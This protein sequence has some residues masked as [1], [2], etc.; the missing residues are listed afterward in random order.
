M[1]FWHFFLSLLLF[2]EFKCTKNSPSNEP[3]WSDGS[4]S[5]LLTH[6]F[7]G[8]LSSY[9]SSA[10]GLHSQTQTSNYGVCAKANGCTY[11][12]DGNGYCNDVEIRKSGGGYVKKQ[13]GSSMF[14]PRMSTTSLTA[15]LQNIANRC[16]RNADF[17][18]SGCNYAG[19]E[20][21]FDIYFYFDS[22]GIVSAYPV[23]NCRDEDTCYD[24]CTDLTY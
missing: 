12:T 5:V 3:V 24:Q 4:P 2:I 16:N 17:C 10:H 11:Y 18:A 14:S 20:Y 19:N 13:G 15:H 22:Y 8:Q 23:W 7:C 9:D 21:L 1:H 6:I